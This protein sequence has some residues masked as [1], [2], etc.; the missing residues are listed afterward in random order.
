[1]VTSKLYTP[2][3]GDIIWINLNPTRGHEQ[4]NVR[5]VLVLTPKEY[6]KILGLF[7]G[8]PITSQEKGYPFEV[9]MREKKVQGVC[10]ADQIRSMNWKSRKIK[11]IQTAPSELVTEVERTLKMLFFT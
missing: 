4:S 5:P 10:L 9:L 8:C 7:I 11:F 6:N 2:D 1:M 3:R